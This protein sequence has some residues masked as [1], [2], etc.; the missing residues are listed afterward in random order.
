M[1][2]PQQSSHEL[3]VKDIIITVSAPL[4]LITGTKMLKI[5]Q[6][7]STEFCLCRRSPQNRF[8]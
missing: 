6:S 2:A 3:N 4:I 5:E 7:D 1:T 8:T